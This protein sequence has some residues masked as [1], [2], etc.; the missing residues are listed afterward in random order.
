MLLHHRSFTNLQQIFG[1]L[2]PKDILSISRASKI[3]RETLMTRSA[4]T[5]WKA[6]RDR[7]GAPECPSW[8]SEPAWAAL[9]FGHLCQVKFVIILENVILLIVHL[10]LCSRVGRAMFIRW[11]FFCLRGCARRVKRISE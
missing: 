10:S 2:S 9:L 11:T 3:F 4:T 1:H 6:A 7:I 5:V 8:M